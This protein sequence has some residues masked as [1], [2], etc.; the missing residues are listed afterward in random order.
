MHIRRHALVQLHF[1]FTA[2]LF[3]NTSKDW[4]CSLPSYNSKCFC[5][6]SLITYYNIQWPFYHFP[7]HGSCQG[8][9]RW[10]QAFYAISLPCAGTRYKGHIVYFWHLPSQHVPNMYTGTSAENGLVFLKASYTAA[11]SELYTIAATD[12]SAIHHN[13]FPSLF[14]FSHYTPYWVNKACHVPQKNLKSTAHHW[15]C[16]ESGPCSYEWS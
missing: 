2:Y 12:T 5:N 15:P 8:M 14:L 16:C 9:S 7:E 13:T 3:P 11:G 4:Y 10:M 1:N 6:G